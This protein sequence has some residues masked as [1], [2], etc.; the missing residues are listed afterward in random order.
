MTKYNNRYQYTISRSGDAQKKEDEW[1]SALESNLTK[2]AVQPK[3]VDQ[4]MFEQ[5]NSIINGKSKYKS[6]QDAVAD[7]QRRSGYLDYIN[8]KVA[9]E[10]S[11]TKEVELFKQHPEIETTFNNYITDTNGTLSVPSVIEHVRSIHQHD[12]KDDSLWEDNSLISY[13][14]K[15]N[16]SSEKDNSTD[17][18]SHNLGKLDLHRGKDDIDK[19]NDDAWAGLMPATKT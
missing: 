4:S 2:S 13:V 10:G 12:V 18:T 7:M 8:K 16:Q 17:T 14:N 6:V 15:L 9:N 11:D 5:I 19:S 1:L 3:R